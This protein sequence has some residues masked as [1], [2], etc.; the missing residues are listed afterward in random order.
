M[1]RARALVALSVMLLL[2]G[3]S[4]I[5]DSGPIV[6]GERVDIAQSDVTVR[7][8]ARPPSPG[9]SPESLVRGFIAACA[10][11]AEGD[12]TARM[13]LTA[14]ASRAWNPAAVTDVYSAAALSVKSEA[15]DTVRIEA[16]LL[17]IIRADRRYAVADP[18][19]AIAD[20]LRLERVDGEWRIAQAP[21]ALYLSE[22]DVARSYRAHALYFLNARLNRLIPE[23]VMVPVAA[24][25]AA[26]ALVRL[27]LDG[28]SSGARDALRSAF[29]AGAAL[30]FGSVN[31][32]Y[33]VATV[34]LTRNV[35]MAN[36]MERA[37]LAAQLTRTLTQLPGIGSVVV[38]VDGEAVSLMQGRT[39][40]VSSDFVAF[41]PTVS[42]PP[43]VFT[44][45][46]EVTLVSGSTRTNPAADIAAVEAAVSRDG[47]LVVGV[48]LARKY[49]YVAQGGRSVVV[50]TGGD[51]AAPT[52]T[53][54]DAAWF[55]DREAPRG[56]FRWTAEIGTQAVDTG[57]PPRARIL[58]FAVAPDGE[59]VALLVN[60][61]TA[62]SLRIGYI[63]VSGDDVAVTGL[64]RVEQQL[65]SVVAVAWAGNDALV[66]LGAVG[67]V[68]VQPISISLPLGTATLLGGPANATS[69]AAVPGQPIVVGDQSGQLWKL[70]GGKWTASEL[71]ISPH[72]SS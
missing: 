60:E 19:G 57:L 24:G 40:Y 13:Y 12:E 20:V 66:A 47:A 33:S 7:V 52:V 11:V 51:I 1:N 31:T 71:G 41:D 37:G 23:Y 56:M 39:L 58:D 4:A 72:Y 2:A 36:A 9:M 17:G 55:I 63:A 35:M 45:D 30:A 64:A 26:T 53:T 32:N 54:D 21:P 16:P 59:R 67:A 61:G 69:L 18:G 14:D 48:S 5:P 49:L 68:A 50:A 25:S 70:D 62:T 27:L 65:T 15:G 29:P 10:S 44:R 34:A 43:L 3:C 46:G 28:P 42:A 22:G 6:K 38:Q 8:I